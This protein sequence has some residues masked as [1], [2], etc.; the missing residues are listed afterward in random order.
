MRLATDEAGEDATAELDQTAG[1]SPMPVVLTDGVFLHREAQGLDANWD[2]DLAILASRPGS[3][4][5]ISLLPRVARQSDRGPVF[6]VPAVPMPWVRRAVGRPNGPVGRGEA[7]RVQQSVSLQAL[8]A[9]VAR[10]ACPRV[11]HLSG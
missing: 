2:E 4:R 1:V 9:A 10:A 11:P 6:G 7:G 5:R 3:E 8:M